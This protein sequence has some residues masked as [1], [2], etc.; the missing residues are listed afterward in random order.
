MTTWHA[1]ESEDEVA[2][3]TVNCVALP[4]SEIA[5]VLVLQVGQDETTGDR[6]ARGLRKYAGHVSSHYS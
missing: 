2:F 4:D 6:L 1:G 3:F 5:D